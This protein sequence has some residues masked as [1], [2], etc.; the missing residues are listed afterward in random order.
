L[1][2]NLIIAGAITFYFTNCFSL[3]L[4]RL[5]LNATAFCFIIDPERYEPQGSAIRMSFAAA[6][7]GNTEKISF[8]R[9]ACAAKIPCTCLPA[10]TFE[11]NIIMLRKI[12]RRE[13]D[14]CFGEVLLMLNW[15]N[16]LARTYSPVC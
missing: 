1:Q 16:F 2:L 6:C 15:C 5:R 11:L 13:K 14:G 4:T 8:Y 3:A 7:V 12:L 9:G 10:T